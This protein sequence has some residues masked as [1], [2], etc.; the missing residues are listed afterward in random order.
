M[1]YHFLLWME[2]TPAYIK[3]NLISLKKQVQR[4]PDQFV[5][6]TR[7]FSHH[8]EKKHCFFFSFRT[9]F[10][11]WMYIKQHHSIL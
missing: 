6:K 9:N 7:S 10:N 2:E 8:A 1:C 11:S 4:F 3:G 5:N